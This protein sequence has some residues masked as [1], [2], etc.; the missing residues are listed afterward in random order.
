MPSLN[1][2][3]IRDRISNYKIIG[4]TLDT[5]A[6]DK[7][8]CNLETEQL[9]AMVQFKG[10][11]TP[12]LLSEAIYGEVRSRLCRIATEAAD[13]AKTG[14]I[15]F[16]ETWQFHHDLPEIA[17]ELGI[18]QDPYARATELLDIYVKSTGATVLSVE[19]GVSV[20]KLNDRYFSNKPPFSSHDNMEDRLPD[21]IALLSMEDWGKRHDGFVIA[22]SNDRA[23]LDF[24]AQSDYIIVVDDLEKVLGL[25]KR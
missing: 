6:F 5:N 15:Q 19:S 13:R 25:F 10:S 4:I 21:A 18:D 24:A 23:W 2:D 16:L 9:K 22:V 8:G 12:F 1:F 3:A 17:A 14:I 20:Q 11:L 7:V